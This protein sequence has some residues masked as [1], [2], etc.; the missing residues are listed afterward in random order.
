M[1][2]T[3]T[4][5]DV[6]YSLEGASEDAQRI[7]SE[8]NLNARLRDEKAYEVSVMEAR[9]KVLVEALKNE[10]EGKEVTEE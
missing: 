7:I 6:E 10:L 1:T 2:D 5:D 9:S 4:I 3:V 8:I